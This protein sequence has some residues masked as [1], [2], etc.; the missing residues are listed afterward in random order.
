[1]ARNRSRNATEARI[2]RALN[3]AE[4]GPVPDI[5]D[6]SWAGYGKTLSDVRVAPP[7]SIPEPCLPCYRHLPCPEHTP[8]AYAEWEASSIIVIGFHPVSDTERVEV[9]RTASGDYM[10]RLMVGGHQVGTTR[11]ANGA[12][13]VGRTN[14]QMQAHS[15]AAGMRHDR[16][17]VAR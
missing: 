11:G 3:D 1:M 10:S 9:I 16:K 5:N 6:P 15:W 4:G 2:A 13:L 12:G 7:S 8:E 14:A 17:V